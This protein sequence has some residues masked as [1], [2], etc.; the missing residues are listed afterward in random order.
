MQRTDPASGPL[1]LC[2]LFSVA[3][4][5]LSPPPERPASVPSSA[6]WAGGAD[7]GS[8]IA[9]EP[10]GGRRY[11]CAIYY[12]GD[13]AVWDQG[14][15]EFV[16]GPRGAE[17]RDPLRYSHFNGVRVLLSDGAGTLE[18]SSAPRAVR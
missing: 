7:G 11:D 14:L 16:S 6:V 3:A 5:S 17:P 2:A 10:L 9:C 1:L 13:G 15:F 18:K 4:C 8:W 12:E